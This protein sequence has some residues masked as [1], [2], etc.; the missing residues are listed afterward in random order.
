MKT[1]TFVVNHVLV[2]ADKGFAEITKSFEQQLG[3][4]DPSVFELLSA[5]PQNAED[6]NRKSRK[7]LAKVAICSLER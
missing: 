2:E 3:K 7:W 5:G 1:S 6:A 4:F